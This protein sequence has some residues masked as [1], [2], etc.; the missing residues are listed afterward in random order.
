MPGLGWVRFGYVMYTKFCGSAF[1][2]A[3]HERLKESHVSAT[4]VNVPVIIP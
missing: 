1:S 2:L 4:L 3:I